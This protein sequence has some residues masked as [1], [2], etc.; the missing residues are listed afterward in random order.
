MKGLEISMW[1]RIGFTNLWFVMVNSPN[2]VVWGKV[3]IYIYIYWIYLSAHKTGNN[4]NVSSYSW[5]EDMKLGVRKV[6]T[7]KLFAIL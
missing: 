2:S 7:S 4:S 1:I 5:G 6:Y 3:D